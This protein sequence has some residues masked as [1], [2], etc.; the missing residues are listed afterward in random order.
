MLDW[1]TPAKKY[2]EMALDFVHLQGIKNGNIP[3]IK[4]ETHPQEWRDWYAYYG[5]RKLKASQELMRSKDEKTVPTLS[6]FDFDAEFNMRFPAPDV[7]K[8][9]I[10]AYPSRLRPFEIRAEKMR[11]KY[12]SRTVLTEGISHEAW[13]SKA[14]TGEFPKGHTWCGALDGTV[15]GPPGGANQETAE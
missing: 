13:L 4:R 6:P 1:T 15:F 9:E 10:G 12:A 5:F 2:A 11:Q 7:P 8:E 14:R 3:V